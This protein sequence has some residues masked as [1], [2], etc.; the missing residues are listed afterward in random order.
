MRGQAHV[1]VDRESIPRAELDATDQSRGAVVVVEAAVWRHAGV[2]LV[3]GAERL[4]RVV[5]A[6]QPGK[7]SKRRSGPFTAY[8]PPGKAASTGLAS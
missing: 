7:H 6:H 4:T 5:T 2:H 8:L 3:G 1:R